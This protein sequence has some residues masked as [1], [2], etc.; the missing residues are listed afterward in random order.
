MGVYVTLQVL[1]S[2]DHFSVTGWSRGL[3]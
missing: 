3:F 2:C 1:F